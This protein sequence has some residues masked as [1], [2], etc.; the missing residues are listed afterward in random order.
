MI[1]PDCGSRNVY[2]TDTLPGFDTE[3]YRRKMCRDCK[4]RFRTV[5][6][7]DDGSSEFNKGYRE[8]FYKKTSFK[9]KRGD[10]S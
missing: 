2:V 4:S 10:E 5:E 7:V 1:C 3:I 6:V 8:A 9:K